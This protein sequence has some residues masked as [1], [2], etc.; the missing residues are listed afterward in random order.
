MTYDDYGGIPTPTNRPSPDEDF[1][2]GEQDSMAA[3]RQRNWEQ[4]EEQRRAASVQA[5][6]Y[7]MSLWGPK[8]DDAPGALA[9]DEAREQ[10]AARARARARVETRKRLR[11]A[12]TGR[13]TERI[14]DGRD[15]LAWLDRHQTFNGGPA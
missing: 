14:T 10:A 3:R 5:V 8:D 13:M 4:V 2:A 15:A 9:Y 6:R 1:W 12:E 11:E 7:T